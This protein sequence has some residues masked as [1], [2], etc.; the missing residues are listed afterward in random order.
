MSIFCWCWRARLDIPPLTHQTQ[1]W[2][3]TLAMNQLV[4]L[5]MPAT[6]T[7]WFTVLIIVSD[8]G[9]SASHQSAV[10]LGDV[11]RRLNWYFCPPVNKHKTKIF[12]FA[13]LFVFLS[14]PILP[15]LFIACTPTLLL[16]LPSA[17]AWLLAKSCVPTCTTL[18][19]TTVK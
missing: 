6:E 18:K 12:P 15:T 9:G 1:F 17:P 14:P 3:L 4:F 19:T 7:L 11:G 2:T 13:T 10:G 8:K 5:S 16:A